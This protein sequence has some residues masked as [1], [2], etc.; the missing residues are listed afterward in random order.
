MLSPTPWVADDAVTACRLCKGP[1]TLLNRK[2]HCRGC[3]QIF[4]TECSTTAPLEQYG[5]STPVLGCYRCA[6]PF[7][8]GLAPASIPTA[9]CEAA[10]LTVYN[11]GDDARDLSVEIDGILLP[12]E[13]ITGA[14]GRSGATLRI[15]LPR[16]AGAAHSIVV[17]RKSLD[18]RSRPLLVSYARPS[19]ARASAL[20][21][22]G[23][24]LVLF[25]ENLGDDAAA[26]A[27]TV[28]GVPAPDVA[29][30]SAHHKFRI[31]AP[32]GSGTAS[33]RVAV[34][35]VE[36]EALEVRRE[37]PLVTSVDPLDVDPR[38]GGQIVLAGVNFGPA[39]GTRV[40]VLLPDIGSSCSDVRVTQDHTRIVARVPPLPPGTS[41]T[42]GDPVR[43]V[44]VVDGIPSAA[45]PTF[46]YCPP[47]GI[48]PSPGKA[49]YFPRR[50]VSTPG[51]AT[52]MASGARSTL[53]AGEGDAADGSTEPTV[54]AAPA[55]L[56][57]PYAELFSAA[58]PGETVARPKSSAVVVAP[59]TPSGSDDSGSS[60]SV[61]ASVVQPDASENE[62]AAAADAVARSAMRRATA[63]RVGG[64]L[65]AE[66]GVSL[67][68]TPPRAWAA[69]AP[70]CTLVSQSV[71]FARFIR[72]SRAWRDLL[73]H[74]PSGLLRHSRLT[75]VPAITPL[76]PLL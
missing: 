57:N 50:V 44:V 53:G 54:V 37:A 33:I 74:R 63:V 59:Q 69:D 71:A 64:T 13:G 18:L 51:S 5:F 41:V 43:L 52:S 32:P 67:A 72:Y 30:K 55:A 40:T 58:L 65:R 73:I 42:S 16:G 15:S 19:I 46:V 68:P 27:V 60:D 9:G 4:H 49:G 1:F 14:G 62:I 48:P 45:A 10:A 76:P 38:I 56:A 70:D 28:D 35:G 2:H 36:S 39:P 29:V 25:G 26:L 6:A 31:V 22:A 11:A 66:G 7:L 17:K 8:A 34:A 12:L 24:E 20:P 47:T 21:T 61:G 3:G 23:G 75:H